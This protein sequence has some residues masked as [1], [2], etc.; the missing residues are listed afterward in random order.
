MVSP[1]III[2]LLQECASFY[3]WSPAQAPHMQGSA[4]FCSLVAIFHDLRHP[5]FA[6]LW[7]SCDIL[8]LLFTSFSVFLFLSLQTSKSSAFTGPLSSSILSTC[9]NHH[10][11]FS[12]KNSSNL[13]T[14][15]ISRIFSLFIL[16]F[17]VFPHIIRNILI[18]VVF[19]LLS[20]SIFNAQHSAP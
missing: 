8:V 12:L 5:T 1:I 6:N 9:P 14:P 18:S 11:L 17:K 10:N 15:V 20:S 4:G 3:F 13:T 2:I 7:Q 16:S 19:S